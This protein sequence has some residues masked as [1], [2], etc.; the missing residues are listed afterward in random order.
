MCSKFESAQIGA[1]MQVSVLLFFLA[2]VLQ[3]AEKNDCVASWKLPNEMVPRTLCN[4]LIESLTLFP[5]LLS[6]WGN[7]LDWLCK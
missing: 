7:N 1:C 3:N 6:S 2:G 4:I 5:Q